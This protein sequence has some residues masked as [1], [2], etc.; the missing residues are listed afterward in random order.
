[1][2][3][4][5]A[6]QRGDAGRRRVQ[7]CERVLPADERG[8]GHRE[9]QDAEADA[10]SVD[11]VHDRE[12]TTAVL[13]PLTDAGRNPPLLAFFDLLPHRLALRGGRLLDHHEPPDT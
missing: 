11:V 5:R 10:R 7:R 1:S 8:E 12:P 2:P 3:R 4:P 13:A 6:L 9:P